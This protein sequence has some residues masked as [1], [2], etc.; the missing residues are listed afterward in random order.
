MEVEL[1]FQLPADELSGLRRALQRGRVQQQRLQARYFDDDAGTLA[2]H[3][4]A[5][6]LRREG[7]R[8]V[9]TL[10]AAGPNAA[11]RLEHNVDLGRGAAGR[12][13]ALDIARHAGTEAGARLVAALADAAPL[14]ERFAI[15]VRRTSRV[16]RSGGAR[17]ELALDEG[18]IRAGEDTRAV[19]EVEFELLGGRI[20]A[21]FATALAWSQRHRL[22]LDIVPKSERGRLLGVGAPYRPAAGSAALRLAPDVSV[23]GWLRRAVGNGLEQTLLN[24]GELAAGSGDPEHVHQVRVGLR[25]LRSVLHEVGPL[26][27]Q[28]DPAWEP[29]LAAAF[30]AFGAHR[31][32]FALQAALAPELEAAGAPP[33]AWPQLAADAPPLP[34]LARDP[35]LQRLLL[36]LLAFSAGAEPAADDTG[37]AR[38]ALAPRL[39]KL[40]RSLVRAGRRFE[41]LPPAQQHR[42][43]K[44]AKRLRYLAEL[45]AD[46]FARAGVERY[47]R[48]IKGAQD[49]LGAHCD[50]LAALQA[51]RAAA[52]QEPAAWFGVGWLAA[53]QRRSAKACR[54]ALKRLAEPFW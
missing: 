48:R 22:W 30:R 21:L 14:R 52:P 8:W 49:A 10:K 13:P 2:R 54:R 50:R 6:R 27:A 15:D 17:I 39:E 3:A 29:A 36:E 45:G 11:S 26:D 23:S 41:E 34:V 7:A 31:D 4:I 46:L 33:I 20:E 16:L 40:H 32:A 24:A 9:Q 53:G 28:V 25:R 5:L 19:L 42:A 38:A 51:L 18:V 35:A 44:R 12:P 47:L 43:R 1:K 37:S